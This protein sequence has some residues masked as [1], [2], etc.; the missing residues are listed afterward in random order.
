M[1]AM[2]NS[3]TCIGG[4]RALARLIGIEDLGKTSAL[5]TLQNKTWP[6]KKQEA[7]AIIM[8]LPLAMALSPIDDDNDVVTDLTCG[9]Y[10]RW[11]VK[12]YGSKGQSVP[13]VSSVRRAKKFSAGTPRVTN[14]TWGC[15]SPCRSCAPDNNTGYTCPSPIPASAQPEITPNLPTSW[16]IPTPPGHV[17]CYDCEKFMPARY[18]DDQPN[19]V[20]ACK[21][22]TQNEAIWAD[23]DTNLEYNILLGS[24]CKRTYCHLYWGCEQPDRSHLG[25]LTDMP[26]AQIFELSASESNFNASDCLNNV[27]RQFLR[28]YLE[29]ANITL[30]QAWQKC[31][32]MLDNDSYVCSAAQDMTPAAQDHCSA[33]RQPLEITSNESMVTSARPSSILLACASCKVDVFWGQMFGYWKSIPPNS[34]PERMRNRENCWYGKECRTQWHNTGHALRRNHACVAHNI[35][36]TGP[37]S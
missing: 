16:D 2:Q 15:F 30:D 22:S 8:S 17:R 10:T 35:E 7:Q 18:R 1:K 9:L 36:R 5:S 33:Y 23:D 11:I 26:I 37:P 25:K 13:D 14:I 34:M 24:F 19:L 6:A 20:Q 31:M 27:D 32:S 28:Q 21:T 29:F 4:R 12:E 3:M